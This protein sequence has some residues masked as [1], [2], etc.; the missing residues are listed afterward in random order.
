VSAA[1]A[2][3]QASRPDRDGPSAPR[4]AMRRSSRRSLAMHR[5]GLQRAAAHYLHDRCYARRSAARVAEFAEY[6]ELTAPY[7]SRISREALG[8]PLRDFLRQQQLQHAAKLLRIRKL[9][10]SEVALRAGFGTIGTLYRWFGAA[11]GVPP[12]TYRRQVM[13]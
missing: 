10:M 1:E 13:K 6:L 8:M 12:G 3:L 5:Y 2:R 4:H 9:P 11:Y 7:L